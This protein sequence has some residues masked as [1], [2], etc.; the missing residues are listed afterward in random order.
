MTVETAF[1]P[2]LPVMPATAGL[3]AVF[4]VLTIVGI[5]ESSK[6][7]VGIFLFHLATLTVLLVSGGLYLLGNGSRKIS[8]CRPT[9]CSSARPAITS[10][11]GWPGWAASG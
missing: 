7:A 6:V 11:T 4:M 3:L 5:A 1:S 10:S 9:S 8:R 2:L